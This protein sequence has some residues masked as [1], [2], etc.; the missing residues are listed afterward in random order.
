MT[1]SL[2]DIVQLLAAYH[3][4]ALAL[5]LAPKLRLAGLTVMCATF[6]LHM[7]FNLGVGLGL[8]GPAFDITSAFGLIYGPAFFLFVRGL[9]SDQARLRPATALHALPALIIAIWQPEPPIPYLFGL[10]S[11]VIYIGLAVLTLRHHARLRGEWRSDDHAISLDW[12][13]HALI[14]FT[15]LAL[16]DI[17]RE[18]IGFTSRALPDDLALAIVIIGVTTLLTLMMRAAREHDARHGALP[19]LALDMRSP[20]STADDAAR[21]SEAYGRIQTLLQQE[22]AWREPR[23]SLA[24]IAHRL[25]LNP[26]DVSRAINLQA[27]TSFARFINTYRI[28]AL[29]ALMADPA[30]HD[31]TIMALAYE[32]GFNSKSAFNRTYR[33]LTGKTPTQAFEDAK[34]A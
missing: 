30:N 23:L 27:Q 25:Q 6:A 33:E 22:E 26:R 32:V 34:S 7:A 5:M 16:L 20:E 19:K 31:R 17:L 10:P 18:I 28:D 12:V 2:L 4:T 11:L 8:I 14:A 15:L 29:N 13:Q 24:E 21:F 9:A 3:C 1:F